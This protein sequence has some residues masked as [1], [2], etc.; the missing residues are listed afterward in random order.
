M[1]SGSIREKVNCESIASKELAV[2]NAARF[3]GSL[4]SRVSRFATL[5]MFLDRRKAERNLKPAK[6][7][8]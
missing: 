2:A 3:V 7:A 6:A 5:S 8:V 4:S 1:P